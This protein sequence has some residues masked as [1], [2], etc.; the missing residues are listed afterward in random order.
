MDGFIDGY[1]VIPESVEWR[2]HECCSQNAQT[3]PNN[4]AIPL[5]S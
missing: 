2:A 5:E 3:R 4:V 1:V